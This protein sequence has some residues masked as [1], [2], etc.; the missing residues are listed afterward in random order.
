MRLVLKNQQLEILKK[1]KMLQEIQKASAVTQ[2]RIARLLEKKVKLKEYIK[3]KK[4]SASIAGN[5]E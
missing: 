5:I 2:K 3:T 1:K 4:V